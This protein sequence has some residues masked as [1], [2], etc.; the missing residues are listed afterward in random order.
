[1]AIVALAML[2]ATAN[3]WKGTA[4]AHAAGQPEPEQPAAAC[5]STSLTLVNQNPYTIWLGENV[6]TGAILTPPGNNWEMGPG[7]SISLCAPADWT[8]GTF[9]ARTECNFAAFQ[10]DPDDD[11]VQC[12]SQSDCC[13]SG[14]TCAQTGSLTQNNHICYGGMC[15]IDCSTPPPG[16]GTN[17]DCSALANSVCVAAAGS[18]GSTY[19]TGSF[20][21]FTGGVCKT[22]DCGSGLSQC[23]GKW[24]LNPGSPTAVPTPTSV[25]ADFGPET[26]ASQFEITDNSTADNGG[27]AATYDV[28][29]LAGYNGPINVSVVSPGGAGNESCLAN[30]CLTDLNSSCPSL[31]QVIEPPT[32]TVSPVSCGM[33]TYCQ[34]GA[35]ETCPS[36]G[37]DSCAGGYACVIGC[38]GP[39]KLCGADYP[40]PVGAPGI[41]DLQCTTTIPSS[42]VHGIPFTTDNSQYRDMY[43]AANDSAT[44]H[45]T[46][47]GV[48]MF[49]GNQGTPTCWGDLDCLPTE[50][51]LIGPTATG[52][53]GLPAYVG[54]CATASSTPGGKPSTI[55]PTDCA[56]NVR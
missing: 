47:Q 10:A 53:T 52:I 12:N 39:G 33:G 8:S 43:D 48:T 22:G 49:S 28:T 40:S 9:W 50:E 13:T 51:C 36:G 41:A 31:L 44:V 23:Q 17:G 25:S 5:S 38:N 35:C 4:V 54:I 27:G 19:T 1:M 45:T 18:S 3:S 15:V 55:I 16:A 29:N 46:H 24:A 21:G 32:S 42:T 7:D 37:G 20:C 11:Y 6:Q 56:S 26:P 2:A 30:G 14:T 34:T